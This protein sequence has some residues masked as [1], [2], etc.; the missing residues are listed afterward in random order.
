MPKK[1][2]EPAQELSGG[3]EAN[4][5]QRLIEVAAVPEGRAQ[6]QC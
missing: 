6:I 4:E 3:S 2:N 5:W 1:S